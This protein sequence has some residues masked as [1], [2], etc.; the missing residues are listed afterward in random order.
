MRIA[1][2]SDLHFSKISWGVTQFLSKEWV[3]NFNLV[4]NRGYDF[5]STP[6]YALI[7]L[8]KQEGVMDVIVSGD[9][10]TT[11]SKKEFLLAKQF[12]ARLQKEGMRVYLIPGNHDHYTKRS[13]KKKT[14]YH[15][16]S[17]KHSED[18]E[19]NL[20]DHG[21]TAKKLMPSWWLVL[22][23]TACSTPLI[24]SN[25]YFSQETE[26]HLTDLLSKIP[27]ED[28][29]LLVNHFPFFQNDKAKRRLIRGPALENI[30]KE[31]PKVQIYL[32][33]HTHRRC[34]ADLRE[35]NLPLILDSGSTAYRFGSWNLLDLEE[36][37]CDLTV[38]GWEK[39]KWTPIS[40]HDFRWKHV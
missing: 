25:G 18:F 27:N 3:G 10:T 34:V 24:S 11:S 9:L 1:H 15:Y 16:F 26:T 30:L 2:I 8:F 22:M 33:G 19:Y 5:S 31:E 35:S 13:Y 28:K 14:F 32:H 12:I 39:Q 17:P 23:D 20:A 36:D 38:F 21:V 40:Q 7:D 6:P 4:F 37:S 29:V